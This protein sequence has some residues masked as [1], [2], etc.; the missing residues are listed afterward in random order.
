VFAAVAGKVTV[1]AVDH[2]DARAHEAGD[3]EDR[4]AGAQCERGVG[5][6]EVV[7]MTKRVDAS[8][9]LRCLPVAASETAEVDV[10]TARVGEEQ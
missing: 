7:E 2:R 3:G 4:D 5:M 6:P 9:D 1:V 8:R 10:P